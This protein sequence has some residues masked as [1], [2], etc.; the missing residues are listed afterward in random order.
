M[1]D[2][3]KDSVMAIIVPRPVGPTFGGGGK[4]AHMPKASHKREKKMHMHDRSK[5][6]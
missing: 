2:T 4:K 5:G 3:K 1:S 6:R